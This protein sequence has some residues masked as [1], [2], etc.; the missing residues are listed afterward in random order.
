MVLDKAIAALLT[1]DKPHGLNPII[2]LAAPP[3]TLV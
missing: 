2:S 3:Q 1:T